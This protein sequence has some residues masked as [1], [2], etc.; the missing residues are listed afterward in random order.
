MKYLET[1]DTFGV[2][3]RKYRNMEVFKLEENVFFANVTRLFKPTADVGK[4]LRSRW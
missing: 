2:G 4:L 3:H 1:H